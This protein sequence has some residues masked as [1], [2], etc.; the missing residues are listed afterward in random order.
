[1]QVHGRLIGGACYCGDSKDEEADHD[2][3]HRE[4]FEQVVFALGTAPGAL[5][6]LRPTEL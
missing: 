6:E 3:S 4:F 5:R 2:D 1:L